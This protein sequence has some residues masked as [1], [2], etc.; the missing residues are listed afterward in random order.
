MSHCGDVPLALLCVIGI[1]DLDGVY[2][3]SYVDSRDLDL[4][5]SVCGLNMILKLMSNLELTTFAGC[6]VE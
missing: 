2:H 4:G 6:L 1:G 5:S 3:T